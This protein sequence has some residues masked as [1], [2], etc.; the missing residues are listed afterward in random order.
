MVGLDD[1]EGLFCPEQ[2]YDSVTLSPE[3][4][5]DPEWVERMKA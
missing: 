5:Y 2:S 1:L 4:S 3:Q